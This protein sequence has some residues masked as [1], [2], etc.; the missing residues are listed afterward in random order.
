M[1]LQP[2]TFFRTFIVV[3][4]LSIAGL[5]FGQGNNLEFPYNPDADGDD[6][7]GTAD[8]LS[9]LSLY[10]SYFS[11]ENLYLNDDSSAALVLIG[12]F[13]YS[14][15]A[16]QCNELPGSWR[17]S[18]L[19]QLGM[20]WD[21]IPLETYIWLESKDSKHFGIQWFKTPNMLRFQGGGEGG[22]DW[23]WQPLEARCYC[24]TFERRKVEY[25]YCEGADIIDC[26]Q[27]R[28]SEGW[29]PLS[30]MTNRTYYTSNLYPYSQS[31][32]QPFWRWAE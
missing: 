5:I 32:I 27:S 6:F 4:L 1:V 11:E 24:A 7:V 2:T 25:S 3:F 15:C 10:D 12:N 30:A 20:V 29:I 16:Y 28:V 9:L 22:V 31:I 21:E 8:L 23:H 26:A 13:P 17:I 19:E 18:T 14:K